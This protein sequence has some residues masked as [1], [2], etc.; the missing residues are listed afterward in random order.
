MNGGNA[1][2]GSKACPSCIVNGFSTS[3]DI[4]GLFAS[5]YQDLYTIVQLN[6]ADVVKVNTEISSSVSS[7]GFNADCIVNIKDV[8]QAVD[9]LNPEKDDGDGGLTSDN[10]KCACY[11]LY[12]LVSILLSGF[13]YPWFDISWL[14][15]QHHYSNP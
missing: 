8:A 11:D 15:T 7:N 13:L 9:K 14:S 3:A 6:S 5:K 4:A 2:L 12:V 10:F 1:D